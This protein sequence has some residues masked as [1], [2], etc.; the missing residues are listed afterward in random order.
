MKPVALFG[1]YNPDYPR[2]RVLRKALEAL[3][4]NYVQL[5][6]R[7]RGFGK[8]L[9]LVGRGARTPHRALY[10]GFPG[11]AAML[12]ARLATRSPIFFDAFISLFDTYVSDR[13]LVRRHSL[14]AG[15]LHLLDKIA[16]GMAS[17]VIV[18]TPQH[19]DFFS[20]ELRVPRGKLMVIPVATDIDLFRPE[21]A[22]QIDVDSFIIYWHGRYSPLHNVGLI[23]DAAETLLHDQ[24][25]V[26]HLLGS[27]GQEYASIRKSA[28]ERRLTNITFLDAVPYEQL[29]TFVNTADVCLGVLGTSDKVDRVVPNKLHE[30]MAC[31]KAVITRESSACREL[32]AGADIGYVPKN[33]AA[34][35]V[36]K[37][38][39]FRNDKGRH[40][41]SQANRRISEMIFSQTCDAYRELFLNR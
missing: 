31:G 19:L 26:F 38:V 14:R 29:P 5:C 18:D 2:N 37:I 41:V 36:E 7:K 25:Y 15:A 30:Y 11:Q 24:S 23:L 34:A 9:R 35:L 22:R 13:G 17:R 33:S 12:S 10:V 16:C 28:D 1:T 32:L 6:E 4:V 3:S 20:R 39:D 8:Y 21:P 40:Y 27:K